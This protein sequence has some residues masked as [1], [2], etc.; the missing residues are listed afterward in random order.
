[1]IRPTKKLIEFIEFYDN[2]RRFCEWAEMDEATLS[3]LLKGDR[4]AT[5]RQMEKVCKQIGWKLDEAW[6][7]VEQEEAA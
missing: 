5:A 1:M 4:G 2:Q 6:E 3:R 7:I